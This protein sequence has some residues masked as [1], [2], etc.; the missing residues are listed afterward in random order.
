MAR[1]PKK[2]RK[3]K[4]HKLFV[5]I[6]EVWVS[7]RE[8]TVPEGTPVE[9]VIEMAEDEEES[10]LEYSHMLDHEYTVVRDEQGNFVR[11]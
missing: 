3:S 9:K 11:G 7:T 10:N 1:K 8:V 4:K 5:E 6:R 2:P